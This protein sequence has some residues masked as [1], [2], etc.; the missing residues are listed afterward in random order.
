[1]F[2]L[3]HYTINILDIIN[4]IKMTNIIYFKYR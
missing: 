1:M 2:F 4:K 3:I